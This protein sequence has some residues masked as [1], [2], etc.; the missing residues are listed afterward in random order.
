MVEW[1]GEELTGLRRMM[2]LLRQQK[3]G[4]VVVI[5]VQRDDAFHKIEVELVGIEASEG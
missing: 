4:D 1:D 3:A 2:R 5:T